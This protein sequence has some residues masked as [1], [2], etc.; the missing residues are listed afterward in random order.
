M[1]G[2]RKIAP[3]FVERP[4][5]RASLDPWFAYNG[6]RTGEVWFETPGLLIKFL[7]TTEALSVQVHPPD[8]YARRHDGSCGKTEMWYVLDAEPGARIAL[9]FREPLTTDRVR[10]A[11]LDGS[12][13][14]L[15]AWHAAAPGDTF[16]TPAGTVH[17]LGPG[18]T[19]LE[20]QQVS[21]VTYR[22]YDY[23]RGRQLHLDQGLAVLNLA[24]HP[25]KSRP[26]P[27]DGGG[28][29]LAR[30]G[31]FTTELWTL[32]GPREFPAGSA[33]VCIEGKGTM[34]GEPFGAGEVWMLD[35][36]A[37]FQPEDQARLVRTYAGDK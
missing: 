7:F 30:C 17:A 16:F 26:E 21:D 19:V 36:P 22:L 28:L 10:A 27:M 34:A 24:P 31:Y 4:W 5:G 29:L 35:A 23:G 18:L 9:G 20:I 25:G 12:I 37:C 13:E 6:G 8:D 11:A 3:K 2:A 32:D 1:P 14:E 33:L 15:L